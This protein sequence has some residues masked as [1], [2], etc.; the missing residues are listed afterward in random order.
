MSSMIFL[1]IFF[2]FLQNEIAGVLIRGFSQCHENNFFLF[3]L[4]PLQGQCLIW[5]ITSPN[6]KTWHILKK[7]YPPVQFLGIGILTHHTNTYDKRTFFLKLWLGYCLN[8][9]FS[10]SKGPS[11]RFQ[12]IEYKICF[13][14]PPASLKNTFIYLFK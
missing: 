3:C 11:V 2:S 5:R 7:R 13:S 6:S 8:K 14:A 9:V 4:F 12:L 10:I 1:R